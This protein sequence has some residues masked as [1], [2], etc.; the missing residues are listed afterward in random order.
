MVDSGF[1]CVAQVKLYEEKGGRSVGKVK[2]DF[3]DRL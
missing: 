2:E 3:V 1:A